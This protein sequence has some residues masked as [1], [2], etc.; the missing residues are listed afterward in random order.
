MS[1]PIVV[2]GGILVDNGTS[3]PVDP[4]GRVR[5]SAP[6]TFMQTTSTS[7]LPS[8]RPLQLTRW[9]ATSPARA[10]CCRT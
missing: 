8:Y 9:W 2:R 7:L 3:L 5:V 1:V 4:F 6:N 10:R